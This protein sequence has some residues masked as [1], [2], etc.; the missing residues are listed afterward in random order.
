[1]IYGRLRGDIGVIIRKLCKRKGVEIIEANAYR[2]HVHMLVS[3]P[4]KISVLSFVG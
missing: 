3:I 2:N 1:M 4:P